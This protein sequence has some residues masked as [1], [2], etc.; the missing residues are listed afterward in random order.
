MK[1]SQLRRDG[2]RVGNVVESSLYQTVHLLSVI[3]T[4]TD[5]VV[6]GG[7]SVVRQQIIVPVWAVSTTE[8]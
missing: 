5:L 1:L 8:K 3:L 2:K 4:E 7:G 6:V